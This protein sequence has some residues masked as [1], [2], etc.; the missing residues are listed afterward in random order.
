MAD[1]ILLYHGK[2]AEL[3]ELLPNEPG[4]CT[5]TLELFIG[6]SN[7]GNKLIGSVVWGES[8]NTLSTSLKS[9]E[10]SLD[11]KLTAS[12]AET[13]VAVA[14]DATTTALVTAFNDLVAKLKAAGIMKT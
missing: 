8:I 10:D 6:T 14:E 5:D 3:P 9:L 11:D 7:G 1:K 13:V 12:E 4:F 2:K